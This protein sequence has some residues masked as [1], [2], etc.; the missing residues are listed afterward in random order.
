MNSFVSNSVVDY[1]LIRKLSPPPLDLSCIFCPLWIFFLV[2]EQVLKLFSL[3]SHNKWIIP[4]LLWPFSHISGMHTLH[5]SPPAQVMQDICWDSA[6]YCSQLLAMWLV[7]EQ[8]AFESEPE[9]PWIYRESARYFFP[10]DDRFKWKWRQEREPI[11]RAG[12]TDLWGVRLPIQ[13]FGD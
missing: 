10:N 12:A 3:P 8:E 11:L 13:H 9:T 6:R 2:S 7:G 1:K 4:P 5:R